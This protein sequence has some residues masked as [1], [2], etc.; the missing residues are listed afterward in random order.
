MIFSGDCGRLALIKGCQALLFRL[1]VGH[2]SKLAIR[3]LLGDKMR[4]VGHPL[5]GRW[6][7]TGGCR[8][9]EEGSIPP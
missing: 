9:T 2:F 7:E 3:P 4:L 1:R 5:A 8:T 6:L